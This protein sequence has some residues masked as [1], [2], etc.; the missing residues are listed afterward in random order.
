MLARDEQQSPPCRQPAFGGGGTARAG[1]PY[2][3][4][5]SHLIQQASYGGRTPPESLRLGC[6]VSHGDHDH[7]LG[8]VSHCPFGKRDLS[9]FRTGSGVTVWL[10]IR[11]AAASSGWMPAAAAR[12]SASRG[13]DTSRCGRARTSLIGTLA[14]AGR[15]RS[16]VVRPSSTPRSVVRIQPPGLGELLGVRGRGSH[17]RVFRGQRFVQPWLHGRVAVPAAP[18]RCPRPAVVVAV[19]AVAA[20]GSGQR[21]FAV[22]AV[23]R[24]GSDLPGRGARDHRRPGG[25]GYGRFAFCCRLRRGD[26]AGLRDE[27]LLDSAAEDGADDVQVPELDDVG[28]AGPQA[29]H[30]AGADDQAAVGK[31]ALQ[32][33]GLPDTAVGR[34]QAQVPLHWASPFHRSATRRCPVTQALLLRI[35]RSSKVSPTTP[36]NPAHRPRAAQHAS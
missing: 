5:R 14:S 28:L 24:G 21:C 34:G 30:L 6:G 16:T 27:Q 19:P 25:A 8:C 4:G 32:L 10:M 11:P 31:H 7:G 23:H 20:A 29:R 18:V 22:K 3:Q 17:C 12:T 13:L 1:R 33:A 2:Y 36:R 15:P 9:L 26:S 35:E